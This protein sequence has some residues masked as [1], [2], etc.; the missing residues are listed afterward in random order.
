MSDP[1]Q[2]SEQPELTVAEARQ[3]F[4]AATST[5]GP[6]VCPCCLRKGRIYRRR[7]NS[8]MAVVLVR[9]H[10]LG[11]AERWVNVRELFPGVTQRG[12]EWARTR[13]WGLVRPADERTAEENARG[14]WKL[15]ERGVEFVLGQVEVSAA[16]FVWDNTPLRFSD[17]TVTIHQ[18][19][20]QRFDYAELMRTGAM[21]DFSASDEQETP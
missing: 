15:T 1:T 2:A 12:G 19:L 4:L 21:P 3:Q 16:V 5:G 14:D 20:G 7:L 11:A 8:G 17:E 6:V 9:L 18:A 10:H 13:F